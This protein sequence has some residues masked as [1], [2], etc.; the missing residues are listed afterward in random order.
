MK[1]ILESK[2]NTLSKERVKALSKINRLILHRESNLHSV[3]DLST[4]TELRKNLEDNDLDTDSS[5]SQ[6][7]SENQ[8]SSSKSL[9]EIF[10][11]LQ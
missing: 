3:Q 5:E 1:K 8:K 11:N 2:L 10:R 7:V 6:T 4:P 9:L